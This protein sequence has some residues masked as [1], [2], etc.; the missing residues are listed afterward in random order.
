MQRVCKQFQG[1]NC[2]ISHQQCMRVS[3]FDLYF[4]LFMSLF[5]SV[6]CKLCQGV[7]YILYLSFHLSKYPEPDSSTKVYINNVN[8]FQQSKKAWKKNLT[9]IGIFFEEISATLSLLSQ[10]E[11]HIMCFRV[12]KKKRKA[13]SSRYKSIRN[14]LSRGKRASLADPLC[15]FVT[16][17]RQAIGKTIIGNKYKYTTQVY[18]H[19]SIDCD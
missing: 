19:L 4:F 5:I 9:R 8:A 6:V 16:K 1:F 10:V 12:K 2:Q 15:Y 17:M 18:I 13:S 11:Y 14:P 3:L 7:G